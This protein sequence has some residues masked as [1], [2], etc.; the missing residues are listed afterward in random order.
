MG[1]HTAAHSQDTLCADG[2]YTFR[3]KSGF[4]ED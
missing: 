1:C 3:M 4:P 2:T